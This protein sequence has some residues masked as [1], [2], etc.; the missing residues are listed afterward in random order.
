MQLPWERRFG[1]PPSR[2]KPC[3]MKFSIYS[4][5]TDLHVFVDTLVHLYV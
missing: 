4:R 1:V 2:P 5:N 3:A